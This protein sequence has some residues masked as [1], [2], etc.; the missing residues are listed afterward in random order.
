MSKK[1]DPTEKIGNVAPFGLRMLPDLRARLEAACAHSGRSMNAEIIARLE[2]SFVAAPE[3]MPVL[4]P[5]IFD[6]LF[7]RLKTI[8]RKLDEKPRDPL[9][10]VIIRKPVGE[11]D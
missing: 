4:T 8:E 11:S 1:K 5:E 10:S 7:G 6:Q 2:A 9:P 3:P